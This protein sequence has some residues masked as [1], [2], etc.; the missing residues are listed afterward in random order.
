M[1]RF[2]LSDWQQGSYETDLRDTV[3]RLL[4]QDRN[5]TALD[6]V[7][8]RLRRDPENTD[9][10][11]VALMI[12][13]QG[14]TAALNSPE[15][16]TD[17][18]RHHALLAPI[19]TECSACRNRW[20]SPHATFLTLGDV[21]I[22][23]INPMGLQCR[24]CRYTLCRE[25]LKRS[26]APSYTDSVDM[27]VSIVGDCA[28]P[29]CG[30]EILQAPV[31]PTGRY[32]VTPTDPDTIEGV[33]VVR[34]GPIRPT[35]EVAL[36]VVTKFLPLI[37]DDAPLLHIRRASPGTMRSEA[38]R[39][40]LAQSLLLDLEREG[41]LVPGAWVR[42][43]R[44]HILAG[45]AQD[46][47][48]LIT[49]VR[50]SDRRQSPAAPPAGVGWSTYTYLLQFLAGNGGWGLLRD[51]H[52]DKLFAGTLGAVAAPAEMLPDI[53]REVI[54]HFDDVARRRRVVFFEGDLTQRE[55][56]PAADEVYGVFEEG[57][58]SLLP[59]S[60]GSG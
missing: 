34:E 2:E 5:R 59:Y 50:K 7:L 6:E 1:R 41:T 17:T 18:Q 14:R 56:G 31:L 29:G 48:Y 39:D 28:N 20:F 44:M 57:N 51:P 3:D 10:L 30:T 45:T 52:T 40:G 58:E 35:T 21:E 26:D 60:E 54:H 27:P 4:R 32:D 38:T 46:T 42:S 37:P 15:P 25:C 13:S 33:V 9:A 49:V 19:V 55:V 11:L 24:K 16:T 36:A 47:D 23:P 8:H 12:L 53:A 22:Q 43:R